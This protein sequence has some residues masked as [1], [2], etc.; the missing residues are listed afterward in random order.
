MFLFGEIFNVLM[1]TT[2]Q[3]KR[4]QSL[5]NLIRKIRADWSESSDACGANLEGDENNTENDEECF[6]ED[7]PKPL[8]DG[9]TKL[10]RKGAKNNL[11]PNATDC[12]KGMGIDLELTADQDR[13]LHTIMQQI[14][15]LDQPLVESKSLPEICPCCKS[16][17]ACRTH[18][19]PGPQ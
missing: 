14:N 16:I 6:E 10:E 1:G 9:S 11:A 8:L 13:E 2:L 3:D 19:S 17:Y 5:F 7:L 12:L 18:E 15:A 4:V